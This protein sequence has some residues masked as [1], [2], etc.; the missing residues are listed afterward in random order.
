LFDVPSGTLQS[1]RLRSTLQRV[2]MMVG[3][4]ERVLDATVAYAGARVQFGR[5]IGKFQ[6]VQQQIAEMAGEV[7]ALR[8]AAEAAGS[9]WDEN[10]SDGLSLTLAVGSAKVQATRTAQVASRV[11]HQ[12]HGA[13]GMT[14]EHDLR[15][16]TTRLWAWRDECGGDSEWSRQVGHEA[17]QV[18]GDDLW[19]FVT[20]T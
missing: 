4:A 12:V 17:L 10:P 2:W 15:F 16:S 13:M 5:P 14:R 6:A 20:Q 7:A 3:A 11:A 9:N 1:I 8:V 18:G 19:S